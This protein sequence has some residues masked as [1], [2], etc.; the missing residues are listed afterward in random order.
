MA[1]HMCVSSAQLS[2]YV[3]SLLSAEE[4]AI[5]F[6][7]CATCSDCGARLA[8]LQ[9]VT[10]GLEEI[11][12]EPIAALDSD[13]AFDRFLKHLP[14]GILDPAPPLPAWVP[15]RLQKPVATM[16][17]VLPVIQ[18][19]LT[20]ERRSSLMRKAHTGGK[21]AL[22]TAALAAGAAY[23]YRRHQRRHA[24]EEHE[25]ATTKIA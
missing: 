6:D 7:H 9:Q 4:H 25:A 3:D 20:P 19:Q 13:E 16:H 24:A 10:A 1:S 8:H 12:A 15:D 21:Y 11:R 5:V 2:D 18:R 22:G 23:A 17:A 14:A